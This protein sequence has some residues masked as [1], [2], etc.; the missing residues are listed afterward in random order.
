MRKEDEEK[1]GF[2]IDHGTFCYQKMLFDLKNVGATYHRLMDKV[3]SNQIGRNV[4]VYFDDMVINSHNKATLFCDIEETFQTLTKM[5]MK[6]NLGKCTFGVEK[7]QFL[8][9]QISKEGI[10]TNQT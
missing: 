4:K 10:S 6:L 9:Y 2:H 3:F 1:V 8:G 7:G 5:Q